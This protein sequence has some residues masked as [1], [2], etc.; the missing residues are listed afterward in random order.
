V[1][2]VEVD[3]VD[4][5]PPQRGFRDGADMFRPAVQSRRL[6]RPAQGLGDP[7]AEF[8]RDPHF[9]AERAQ[10][11]ADEQFVGE[12]TV[13]LGRVEEI[14]AE[15]GGPVHGADG[16][17]LVL[18]A[19]AVAVAHRHAAEPDRKDAQPGAEFPLHRRDL[20]VSRHS[21]TDRRIRKFAQ[22]IGEALAARPFSGKAPAASD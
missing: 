8:G 14:N 9:V 20:P 18:A 19:I 6:A 7:E 15:V 4:P 13:D 21:M 22:A 17:A 16:V 5:H 10:R 3:D 11:L 1:L 2:I 12:G